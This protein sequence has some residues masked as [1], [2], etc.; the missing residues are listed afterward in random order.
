MEETARNS[1]KYLTSFGAGPS[2]LMEAYLEDVITAQQYCDLV[3]YELLFDAYPLEDVL[4]VVTFIEIA[5]LE[6]ANEL[7]GEDFQ[8]EIAKLAKSGY[9]LPNPAA[10]AYMESTFPGSAKAV[11]DRADKLQLDVH[12]SEI[13]A[14]NERN[15]KL[16]RSIIANV[17]SMF[18]IV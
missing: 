12:E 13:R 4:A 1:D 11:M 8:A 18:G 15:R 5:L 2:P 10:L 3:D 17:K 14:M 16:S 9:I 6:T 7:G